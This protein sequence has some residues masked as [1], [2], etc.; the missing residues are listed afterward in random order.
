MGVCQAVFLKKFGMGRA[1]APVPKSRLFGGG[2]KNALT[3]F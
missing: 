1:A 3:R 2:Q